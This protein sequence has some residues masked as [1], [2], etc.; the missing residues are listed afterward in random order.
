[1]ICMNFHLQLRWWVI[2][3]AHQIGSF[4]HNIGLKNVRKSLW[5][6]HL[7]D[8]AGYLGMIALI[9][10]D[11]DLA[12]WDDDLRA[13]FFF[14][15]HRKMIFLLHPGSCFL[16]PNDP[17]SWAAVS[18][19]YGPKNEGYGARMISLS[20]AVIFSVPVF[21]VS[22]GCTIFL[23]PPKSLTNIWPLAEVRISFPG[24]FSAGD[25]D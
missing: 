12:M 4:P 1:M 24:P 16:F 22:W 15:F 19:W 8:L 7:A 10:W 3:H 5:N 9:I 13:S 14:F 17:G 23:D 20:K 11:D 25:S 18:S 6:H 2:A 21:D